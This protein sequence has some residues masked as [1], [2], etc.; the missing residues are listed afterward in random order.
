MA[1]EYLPRIADELLEKRLS[2]AGA[3]LIRGAK[4]C[5]KTRT[6]EQQAKSA[7][8][9]QDPDTRASNLEL[10]EAKPSKRRNVRRAAQLSGRV[11]SRR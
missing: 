9:L 11:K 5:G 2:Y 10:A 1:A 4:W 3:V 6:A 8:Y 7:L